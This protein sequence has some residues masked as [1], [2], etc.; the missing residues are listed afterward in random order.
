MQPQDEMV[1]EMHRRFDK[2]EAKLDTY[3][4][5]TTAAKQD[6]Q[7]LKGYVKVSL[8]ALIALGGALISAAFKLFTGK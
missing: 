7:W 3:A 5:Q 4:E 2:L 6:L 1:Q 8:S